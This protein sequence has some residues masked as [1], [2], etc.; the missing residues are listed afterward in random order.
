L[1]GFCNDLVDFRD[2][3]F[4]ASRGGPLCLGC[5]SST[6]PLG[7]QVLIDDFLDYY[8]E[9]RYFIKSEQCSFCRLSSECDGAPVVLIKERGFKALKPLV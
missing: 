7:G 1:Q 4:L 6:Q 5:V 2:K 3:Q 9:N 8:I